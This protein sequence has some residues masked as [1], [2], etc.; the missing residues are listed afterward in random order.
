MCSMAKLYVCVIGGWRVAVRGSHRR[1]NLNYLRR[2]RGGIAGAMATQ[3]RSATS[4]GERG[5]ARRG[6]K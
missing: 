6:M 4:H 1:I 2:C 5:A 3:A